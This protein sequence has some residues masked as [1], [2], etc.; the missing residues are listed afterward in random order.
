MTLFDPKLYLHFFKCKLRPRWLFNTSVQHVFRS[1]AMFFFL[2]AN[3]LFFVLLFS[4]IKKTLS[5][6][7]KTNKHF[8]QCVLIRILLPYKSFF[9][10]FCNVPRL[11]IFKDV[12]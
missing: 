5:C 4:L 11:L 9:F 2:S 1:F 10:V 3:D 7:L 6:G 12:I 8:L